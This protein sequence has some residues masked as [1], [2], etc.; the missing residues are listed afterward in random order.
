MFLPE[1]NKKKKIH[2]SLLVLFFYASEASFTL[3]QFFVVDQKVYRT[4][5]TPWWAGSQKISQES[6][7]LEISF[8]FPLI[9][10]AKRY[11]KRA[12]LFPLQLTSR[13]SKKIDSLFL[14]RLSMCLTLVY[15]K[16]QI[17]LF[18]KETEMQENNFCWLGVSVA[19]NIHLIP[20]K[21]HWLSVPS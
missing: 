17:S 13:G 4:C 3:R 10:E 6:K 19:R 18:R 2:S 8:G 11:L 9:R 5:T 15:N 7:T 1:W 20:W 14:Q 16:I 21:Q 12:K